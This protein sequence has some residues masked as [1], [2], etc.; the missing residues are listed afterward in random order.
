MPTEKPM[1]T[2]T[3]LYHS[4]RIN[5]FRYVGRPEL[6]MGQYKQGQKSPMVPNAN[7]EMK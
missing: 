6:F 1:P 2:K 4:D 7:V 5:P 3:R